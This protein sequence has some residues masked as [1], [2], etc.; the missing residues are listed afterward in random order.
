M[1][2]EHCKKVFETRQNHLVLYFCIGESKHAKSDADNEPNPT[3]VLAWY[4]LI[5][6][7]LSSPMSQ[8]HDDIATRLCHRHH[9]SISTRVVYFTHPQLYTWSNSTKKNSKL[10]EKYLRKLALETPLSK[11][12]TFKFDTMS[13]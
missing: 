7:Y 4:R 12:K 6:P 8:L 13:H 9:A 3:L 11:L 1:I 10:R 5:F 2:F